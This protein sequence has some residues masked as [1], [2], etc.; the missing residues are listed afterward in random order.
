MSFRVKVP[1]H[2]LWEKQ[3]K[4]TKT[5]KYARDLAD[6][7]NNRVY[8]WKLP[9]RQA[10]ARSGSVTS[11]TSYESTSSGARRIYNTRTQK[12]KNHGHLSP[13]K[14]MTPLVT[15]TSTLATNK[16][17]NLSNIDLTVPQ[18]EVLDLG[19]NFSPTAKFD[20]FVAIKDLHLFARKILLIKFHHKN[21][22][23]SNDMTLDMEEEMEALDALNAL[24]LEQ[25]SLPS[26]T[27]PSYLKDTNDVLRKMDGLQLEDNM[28]LVTCDIESLYTSIKHE[29]GLTA[30]EQFLMMSSQDDV[31]RKSTSTNS[32]LHFS[33]SH[34]SS[35]IWGIPVGQFLRMRQICSDEDSFEKQSTDLSMRFTERGYSSQ[36]IERGYW[37]AKRTDRSKALN[38]LRPVTQE[39]EKMESQNF[40]DFSDQVEDSL[41]DELMRSI[42]DD[43]LNAFSVPALVC[44]TPGAEYSNTNE[45]DAAVWDLA[46]DIIDV[47]LIP[48][49]ITSEH[50]Q[51]SAEDLLYQTPTPRNSPVSRT[52]KKPRGPA[53]KKGKA[54]KV[55][56]RRI[57]YTKENIPLLMGNLTEAPEAA[58]AIIHP[59]SLVRKCIF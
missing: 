50:N 49:P 4:E 39:F 40:W 2:V 11:S 57:V 1:L 20:P 53:S 19:L 38:K 14:K 36:S 54:C 25:S 58:T 16:V 46:Q 10:R 7:E 21:T 52:P 27:L 37:R 55:K 22:I 33:S 48:E 56:P 44:D 18:L 31:F 43:F 51:M 15:G 30:V 29:D 9:P 42:P 13:R 5:K 8:K 45:A 24:L 3:I 32:L 17:I 34:Q 12:R 6:K 26:K 59:T 28:V 41:L 23:N 35:L 47:D